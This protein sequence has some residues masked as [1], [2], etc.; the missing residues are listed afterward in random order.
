MASGR[1]DLIRFRCTSVLCQADSTKQGNQQDQNEC[2]SGK[3]GHVTT[4]L[5]AIVRINN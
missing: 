4:W 3:A 1:A 5:D 2:K